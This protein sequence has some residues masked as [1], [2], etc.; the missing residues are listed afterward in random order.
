M[1]NLTPME[2][3]HIVLNLCNDYTA[4]D[5]FPRATEGQ[6]QALLDL[7]EEADGVLLTNAEIERRWPDDEARR[8][9]AMVDVLSGLGKLLA[10]L[11]EM[12]KAER[13]GLQ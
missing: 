4:Q 9:Q 8:T 13:E 2:L 10:E 5:A 1:L 12:R 6:R 3:E 7:V 11:K